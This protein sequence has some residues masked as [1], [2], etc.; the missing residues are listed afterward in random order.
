MYDRGKGLCDLIKYSGDLVCCV[1][2][3]FDVEFKDHVRA[4]SNSPTDGRGTFLYAD[5]VVA[6]AFQQANL[7]YLCLDE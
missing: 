6:I 7:D 5:V 4:Q 1:E 3:T 2:M